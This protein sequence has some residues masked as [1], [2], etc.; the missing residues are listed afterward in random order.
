M[1]ILDLMSL[2]LLVS[3]AATLI[4]KSN[5]CGFAIL[6]ITVYLSAW[7]I[8]HLKGTILMKT[9]TFTVVLTSISP[10]LLWLPSLGVRGLTLENDVQWNGLSYFIL[11]PIS[12]VF[13]VCNCCRPKM[14]LLHY[15]LESTAECIVVFTLFCIFVGFS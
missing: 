1:N 4:A 8:M 6:L 2:T 15:V 5:Y 10:L 12:I 11:I 13:F 9:V 7:R 3:L 14:H